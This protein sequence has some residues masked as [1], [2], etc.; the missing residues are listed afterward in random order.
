VTY[1]NPVG[2]PPDLRPRTIVIGDVH[3][4]IR[5]LEELL[6]RLNPNTEPTFGDRIVFLGDLMDRGPDPVACVRLARAM[7]AQIVRSNHDEK[8]FRWRRHHRV[9]KLVGK[10]NP[11]KFTDAQ[12]VQ[13]LHLTESDLDWF[14]MAPLWLSLGNNWFAVHAGLEPAKTFDE[15]KDC[16]ALM[17][18]RYINEDGTAFTPKDG[19]N[20]P[21]DKWYWAQRW[22]H[23]EKIVYGHHIH[24][25]INPR[26]DEH[27]LGDFNSKLTTKCIGIDTGCYAGGRLTAMV[28]RADG[29]YEFEH[30]KARRCYV[31]LSEKY[32]ANRPQPAV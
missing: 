1:Q 9:Q 27:R 17:R 12:I 2:T 7:N 16:D 4:C 30:A 28:L 32:G 18:T 10:K 23:P 19:A 29:S 14:A 6:G 26:T 11:I 3:G 31:E 20:D 5:E 13:N 15:Q 25:L 22:F 8:H 24:S 21:T